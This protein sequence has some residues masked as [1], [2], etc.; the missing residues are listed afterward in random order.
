LWRKQYKEVQESQLWRRQY[1]ES[2]LCRKHYKE[3]QDSQFPI[4]LSSTVSSTGQSGV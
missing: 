1:K 3:V 2:Q 4:C